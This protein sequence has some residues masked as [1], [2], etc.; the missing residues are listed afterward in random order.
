MTRRLKYDVFSTGTTKS[1]TFTSS[2]ISQKQSFLLFGVNN[3]VPINYTCITLAGGVYKCTNTS[4]SVSVSGN[5][6]T[7]TGFEN[8]SYISVVGGYL[9]I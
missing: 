2:N 9:L 8:W 3:N 1:I 4:L 5:N 6:I 7:V